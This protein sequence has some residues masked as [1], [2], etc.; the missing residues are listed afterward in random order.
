MR[1]F[2]DVIDA[3]I[4]HQQQQSSTTATNQ[5]HDVV[6]LVRYMNRNTLPDHGPFQQIQV[7]NP[8][9]TTC[10][11]MGNFFPANVENSKEPIQARK[12]FGC[13]GTFELCGFRKYKEFQR[14]RRGG[15]GREEEEEESSNHHWKDILEAHKLLIPYNFIALGEGYGTGIPLVHAHQRVCKVQQE[16]CL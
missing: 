1:Q 2:A 15:S 12:Q 4:V 7:I 6:S 16:V 14:Q 13:P 3:A 9:T 10:C 8:H 5:H 11:D